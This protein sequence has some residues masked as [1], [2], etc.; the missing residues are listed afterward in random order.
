MRHNLRGT[1]GR[2]N[3]DTIDIA[4][5]GGTPVI[6]P[7]IP[8]GIPAS[9]GAGNP[10]SGGRRGGGC[11]VST[12]TPCATEVVGMAE[13]GTGKPSGSGM[14]PGGGAATP[15]SAGGIWSGPITG[16]EGTELCCCSCC[17]CCCCM[18]PESE[19]CAS[20]QHGRIFTANAK[21]TA[22]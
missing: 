19:P 7:G 10:P 13:A 6:V 17:C 20:I 14:K 22:K 18:W 8:A 9:P 5:G 16:V 12:P 4:P 15:M 11:D 1:L 3:G 2:A 21:L